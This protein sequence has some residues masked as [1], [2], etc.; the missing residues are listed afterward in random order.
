MKHNDKTRYS[1]SDL[2][3]RQVGVLLAST[4][5]QR[6]LMITVYAICL[7]FGL[8][9]TLV[10]AVSGHFFG[11]HDAHGRWRG[12]SRGRRVRARTGMPG[13]SFFSPTVLACFVTA[14]GGFGLIF[15]QISATAQRLGQ[16][17]ALI[18]RRTGR[19][20]RGF[21]LLM[22]WFPQ[23]AK[24]QRVARGRRCWAR[25]RPSSRPFP[26]NGVGEIAYVQS[27]TRYSAPAR[28]EKGE[29]IATGQTV[30]ITR[31][32]GTQFYVQSA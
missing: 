1:F 18:C 21:W 25:R 2:L 28:S 15:C 23:I 13:I 11:G 16:R 6:G 7:V 4:T 31:I 20:A 5:I 14:L 30:K 26:A 27:G 32:V 12:R 17:A 9:F 24:F 22:P 3:W 19:S 29:A 8:V 10:S